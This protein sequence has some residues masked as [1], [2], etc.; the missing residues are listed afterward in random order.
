[1]TTV[2][3]PIFRNRRGLTLID[4]MM[5]LT[6]CALL[7]SAIAV[8]FSSSSQA[9]NANDQFTRCAQS[10]R[11]AVGQIMADVRQADAVQVGT[12]SVDIIRPDAS[13]CTYSYNA[14]NKNLV[15]TRAGDPT[16]YVLASDV[17]SCSFAADVQPDPKTQI[18][19][20]VRATAT[21]TVTTG[22]NTVTLGGSAAPRRAIVY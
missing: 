8:A 10:C 17:T 16:Q 6:I 7:L 22:K 9:I 18:N 13:E 12:A 21:I 1:M 15:L 14:T 4:A 2:P 3:L 19:R 20:V 5:S 11:V